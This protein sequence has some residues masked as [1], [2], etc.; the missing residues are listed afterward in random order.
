MVV[1]IELLSPPTAS[2]PTASPAIRVRRPH[3]GVRDPG[4]GPAWCRSARIASRSLSATLTRGAVRGIGEQ[5]GGKILQQIDPRFA[6]QLN[7]FI[8]PRRPASWN[9]PLPAPGEV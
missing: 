8:E 2:S 1:R 4:D 3:H 7:S 9:R 5:P 6:Q